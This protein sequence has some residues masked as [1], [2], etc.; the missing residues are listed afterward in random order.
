MNYELS[1]HAQ[2]VMTEREIPA[3]WLERALRAP[4]RTE[5][6]KKDPALVHHLVAIPE[7][8]GRVLR[9]VLNNRIAPNRIVTLHFD[10]RLKGKL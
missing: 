5:P 6:D 3:A 7:H 2:T 10:R 1:R 9:V 8:G 4:A